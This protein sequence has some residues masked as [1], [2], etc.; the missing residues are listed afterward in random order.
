MKNIGL[1]VLTWVIIGKT[2]EKRRGGR[3]GP[4]CDHDRSTVSLFGNPRGGYV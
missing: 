1:A 4:Q 2:I 3:H